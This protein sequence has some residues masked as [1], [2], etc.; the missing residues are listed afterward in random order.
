MRL[1]PA[2]ILAS[3]ILASILA[4][5]GASAPANAA[6]YPWCARYGGYDGGVPN[7]GFTSYA[8][9]MAAVSGTQGFFEQNWARNL[10]RIRAR[11]VGRRAASGEARARL[12]AP[13][14]KFGC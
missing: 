14:L 9:C 12:N 13:V 4:V 3:I 1:S 7:C 11:S 8:Q 2:L 10:P 5:A 6:D